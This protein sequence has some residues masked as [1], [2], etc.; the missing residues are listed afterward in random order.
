MPE[1]RWELQQRVRFA[2]VM[3]RRMGIAGAMQMLQDSVGAGSSA[4]I[5]REHY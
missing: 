4:L 3:P 1:E 5:L 2:P